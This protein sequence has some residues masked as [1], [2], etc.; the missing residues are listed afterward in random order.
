MC[1]RG[2]WGGEQ[3]SETSE[4]REGTGSPSWQEPEKWEIHHT[5][6]CN[7]SQSKKVKE[8]EAKKN[9]QELG[10]RGTGS[11]K[12]G[13]PCPSPKCMKVTT[14]VD[15]YIEKKMAGKRTGL[16]VYMFLM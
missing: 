1:E 2:G 8:D 11:K 15:R 13:L 7:I 10:L 6:Q 16:N 3:G 14:T 9:R 4:K 5:T 12:Y